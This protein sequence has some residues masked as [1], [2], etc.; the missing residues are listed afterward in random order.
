[1][2]D[3]VACVLMLVTCLLVACQ[4]ASGAVAYDQPTSP[5]PP[6]AVTRV[7]LTTP[8][9]TPTPAVCT[10]LPDDMNLQVKPIS[11]T[12]VSIEIEGL[13]PGE[14]LVLICKT[15]TAQRRHKIE[16]RPLRPVGPDGR[17][18]FREGL[19]PLPGSTTN[20]WEIQIVHAR[21]VACAEVTLSQSGNSK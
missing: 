15:E 17:F 1:M 20:R 7:V 8:E 21:G 14:K 5:T 19:L 4:P 9:P 16:E 6:V 3:K 11:S 10:P 2:E 12:A 13:Q 18:V